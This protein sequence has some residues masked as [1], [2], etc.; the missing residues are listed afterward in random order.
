MC[1][2]KVK[3]QYKIADKDIV[4]YKIL[5]HYDI[6]NDNDYRTI[7]RNF[8]YKMNANYVYVSPFFEEAST[9]EL[10]YFG[11]HAFKTKYAA[12]QVRDFVLR[13]AFSNGFYKDKIV[14]VAKFIIPKGAKYYTGK[15]RQN[16]KFY[17]SYSSDKIVFPQQEL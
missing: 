13:D 15:F 5:Y 17:L 12:L 1:L 8:P 10:I 3:E 16:G 14:F 2:E 9:N 7:Y 11:Y 6:D 4:C